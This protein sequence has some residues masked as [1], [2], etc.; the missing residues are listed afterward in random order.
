MNSDQVLLAIETSTRWSSIALLRGENVLA[1][2]GVSIRKDHAGT[3]AA[4]IEGLL[5]GAGIDA[6][7]VNAVAVSAGPGSFTG[8]RVGAGFAKGFLFGSD[9]KLYA[10]SVLTT[11]AAGLPW[12]H[13]P[14]CPFLDA[15]KGEVYA[16]VYSWEGSGLVVRK[17]PQSSDPRIFLEGLEEPPVFAGEG[18]HT[19][20]KL[21]EERFPGKACIAPPVYGV[22]RAGV[23]GT[24]AHTGGDRYLVEDPAL[25]EPL[26]IRPPEAVAAW[27]S[28][29]K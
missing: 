9:R 4:R 25:F 17:Q 18:S 1:E 5:T 28:R 12:S 16:A 15:R 21:I 20:R 6:D 11:I 29:K 24:L 22:P 7:G 3:L 13:R 2:L 14:V 8:L 26:Y 27:R 10:V 19:F 23:M